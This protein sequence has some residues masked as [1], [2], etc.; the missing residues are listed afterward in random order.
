MIRG[1]GA[2]R[3][4]S[5][6]DPEKLAEDALSAWTRGYETDGIITK[7]TASEHVTFHL[8]TFAETI[9]VEQSRLA[10]DEG[11]SPEQRTAAMAAFVGSYFIDTGDSVFDFEKM[12][13]GLVYIS[14]WARRNF[15]DALGKRPKL[16]NPDLGDLKRLIREPVDGLGQHAKDP[17][18]YL[19]NMTRD[20]QIEAWPRLVAAL[21]G[22]GIENASHYRARHVIP[23]ARSAVALGLPVANTSTLNRHIEE[24][25][26][27]GRSLHSYWDGGRV[28]F[29]G[30]WY[31][32][33]A[34][35]VVGVGAVESKN[36]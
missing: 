17:E 31:D 27:D 30:R 33:R 36:P 5:S 14:P 10:G 13:P 18:A 25:S 34:D 11:L 24:E 22:K 4:D 21:A 7:G 2:P 16:T 35:G 3:R 23:Q 26:V 9:S 12:L 32:V 1:G 29:G 19:I 6:Q 15:A 8:P 20:A 28:K